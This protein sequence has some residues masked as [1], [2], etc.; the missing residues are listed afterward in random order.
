MK[1]NFAL[2]LSHE[3]I[4][5]LHRGK[6]GWTLVGSVAL[7]DPDMG[8]RLDDLRR[9]AA[10]LE[11]GGFT[12]KLVIPNSQIL[13]TTVD[14]AGPDDIAREV[15][16][17]AALDGLTPYAVGDLVF[18]WRA[19]GARARVAVL[20]RE[21]MDEAETFAS[22]YK[23]NP[24][25]FV[26][27]PGRGEFS[28]EP[29][30]G[31][32]RAA[33]RLLPPGARLEPDATPL[34]GN[35][36]ALELSPE[37]RVADSED[38]A[39]AKPAPEAEA[40]DTAPLPTEPA[41]PEGRAEA[42]ETKPENAPA[43]APEAPVPDTAP[44]PPPKR[45]PRAERG[46][47]GR[48]SAPPLAPFPP[49]PDELAAAPKVPPRSIAPVSRT[50]KVPR[51]AGP[52]LEAPTRSRPEA[53]DD[54]TEPLSPA[55]KAPPPSTAPRTEAPDAAQDTPS[56]NAPS[57]AESA[58]AAFHSRRAG[59]PHSPEAPFALGEKHRAA[60]SPNAAHARQDK[61]A[62]ADSEEPAASTEGTAE[63]PSRKVIPLPPAVTPPVVNAR[64]GMAEALSR[65][66]PSPDQP[67][68]APS[69]KGKL[70]AGLLGAARGVTEQAG[71]GLKSA[72]K[73]A[74]SRAEAR[75][76][77]SEEAGDDTAA[78][79]PA[80]TGKDK[81]APASPRKGLASLLRNVKSKERSELESQRAREAEALTVFG[82]RK[83]QDTRGRPKYLGLILTLLLLLAMAVLAVWSSYVIDEGDVTLFNPEPD[84]IAATEPPA[85]APDLPDE[86]PPAPAADPPAEPPA[87]DTAAVLSPEVAA[88]RYAATGIW[89]RAPEPLAEPETTRLSTRDLA[90]LSPAIVDR[91]ALPSLNE[92]SGASRDALLATPVPPPP[93][94]TSFDLDENG[95]VQ[96]TPEGALSPTGI[97]VFAGPPARVP[98]P[99][100]GDLPDVAP[101]VALPDVPNLRPQTRPSDFVPPE[102]P[103]TPPDVPAPGTDPEGAPQTGSESEA[104][105]Q[106][107]P[108]LDEDD[109]AALVP[110]GEDDAASGIATTLAAAPRPAPRPADLVVSTATASAAIDA[111]VSDAVAAALVNPTE[112]AIATSRKPSARPSNFASIVDAAREAASD[113]SRVAAAPAA[114]AAV[115]TAASVAPAIPTSAS[116]A[117]QATVKNALNLRDINLVGIYGTSSARR[118]LVRMKNGRYVKVEIGDRLDGG[119][120]TSITA[121]ELTYQKGNRA[122]KLGVLPLG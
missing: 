63:E 85:S 23:F 70:F 96:P 44:A 81:A 108:E 43:L 56:E 75:R 39:G 90:E 38:E 15:Q 69:G 26:A 76:A 91:P 99:R 104:P 67:S 47:A 9:S 105:P 12:T 21:T 120:V 89:Q 3:G 121:T 122:F 14:A 45:K 27:R 50:S 30:F 1:P 84:S 60:T 117:T 102:N 92:L 17:R 72:A 16:I 59:A 8:A 5:L 97:L 52:K 22:D 77:A 65:P 64:A 88:A 115:A 57:D 7:D 34:P 107:T 29:F 32:T 94:G 33:T 66:L 41:A 53:T 55:D 2:D 101:P 79:A 74:R 37:A 18:D 98:P 36:K 80:E 95:L 11:S 31:K 87:D 40:P 73:T 86:T 78:E 111:A 71:N 10:M 112:L 20:A 62:A 106:S 100:P 51:S 19:E 103:I 61:T 114:T 54:P 58:P 49:T 48:V 42:D 24:V 118:A 68:E 25:S 13:Y 46:E 6:A 110:E 119:R 93:P 4:N 83:S 113:G 35:P 82:A 28:G 109:N 116:V